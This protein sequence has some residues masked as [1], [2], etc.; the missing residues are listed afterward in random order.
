MPVGLVV[1]PRSSDCVRF[2]TADVASVLRSLI[3]L[4]VRLATVLTVVLGAVV[5][6][7]VLWLVIIVRLRSFNRCNRSV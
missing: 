6:V 3:V 2:S 7:T 1:I 5:P 4:V